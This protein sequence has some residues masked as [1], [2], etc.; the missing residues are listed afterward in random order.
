MS[1]TTERPKVAPLQAA[2]YEELHS[3]VLKVLSARA[4][5]PFLLERYVPNDH[6]PTTLLELLTW[7]NNQGWQD[8]AIASIERDKLVQWDYRRD[9]L[10]LVRF[11]R[12]AR[13][14]PEPVADRLEEMLGLD[15]P[16]WSKAYHEA[17]MGEALFRLNDALTRWRDRTEAF[18]SL[19][20]DDIPF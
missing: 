4:D 15:D 17:Q 9:A 8:G 12:R 20:D 7:W 3:L 18:L 19:R 1:E 2:D 13:K 10:G 14:G 16:E 11:A 6:E 5:A